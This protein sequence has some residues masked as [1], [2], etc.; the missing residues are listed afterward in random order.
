[1]NAT[2]KRLV[3]LI[4]LLGT[5]TVSSAALRG[6]WDPTQPDPWVS[7]NHSLI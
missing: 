6:C 2:V 5:V 4:V 7:G 3:A 1:M